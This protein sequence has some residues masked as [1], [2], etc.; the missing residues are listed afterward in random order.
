[1]LCGIQQNGDIAMLNGKSKRRA[2]PILG[3]P[4]GWG[5]SPAKA[6]V[7]RKGHRVKPFC[8]CAGGWIDNLQ[9]VQSACGG[10]ATYFVSRIS[11][12]GIDRYRIGISPV[13]VVKYGMW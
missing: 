5:P 9:G 10:H 12:C 7:P 1:M 11:I 2:A 6:I 4:A 13:S 3:R 8:A